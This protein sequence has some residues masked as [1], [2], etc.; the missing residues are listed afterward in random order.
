MNGNVWNVKRNVIHWKRYLN[1]YT[2]M[3]AEDGYVVRNTGENRK[4][5]KKG[6]RRRTNAQ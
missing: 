2:K 5:M 4:R 1:T 6:T 3:S